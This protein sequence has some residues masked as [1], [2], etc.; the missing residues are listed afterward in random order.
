ML[1]QEFN[2]YLSHQEE[3]V[4]KHQDKYLVIVGDEVKAV[5]DTESE[6]YFESLKKF[7]LGTFLIQFC[8]VGESAYSHTPFIVFHL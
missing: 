5:Y 1:E 7:K 6:A 4:K 2:Y 3:L 8:Q